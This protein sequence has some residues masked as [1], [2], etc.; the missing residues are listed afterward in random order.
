[1]QNIVRKTGRSEADVRASILRN[2]PQARLVR[3]DEVAAAV[4]FLCG[5][6]SDAMTGQAIAVAG[7][8]IM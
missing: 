1:M 5:P 3:P 4:M 2:N 7:G 6:G 8:E